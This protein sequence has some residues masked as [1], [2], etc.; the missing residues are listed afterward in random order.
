[1]SVYDLVTMDRA[2]AIDPSVVRV[3]RERAG[4]TQLQ[5]A[6]RVGVVGG[7]RISSWERGFSRPRTPAVLHALAGALHVTPASLL[8]DPPEGPD[9]RWLRFVAGLSTAELAELV[10]VSPATIQRWESGQRD[11]PLPMEVLEALG[12]A[13]DVLPGQVR[14][15][16]ERS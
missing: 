6:L 15:A 7:E 16:L 8:A 5:L 12:R 10:G 9:L 1:M 14:E 13:L 2:P 4:L 3:A 11:R